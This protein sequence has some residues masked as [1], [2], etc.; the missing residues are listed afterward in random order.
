MLFIIRKQKDV[1]VKFKKHGDSILKSKNRDHKDHETASGL[2]IRFNWFVTCAQDLLA[3][4]DGYLEELEGLKTRADG[5]ST[6]V[7]YPVCPS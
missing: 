5:T 4:V 7:R 3:K 1:V 2:S 6:S